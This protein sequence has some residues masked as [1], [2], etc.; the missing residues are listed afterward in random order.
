[1]RF[2][3]R[4]FHSSDDIEADKIINIL[5]PTSDIVTELAQLYSIARTYE[6][7]INHNIALG[8]KNISEILWYHPTAMDYWVYTT[9]MILESEHVH[10]I[11][12]T[13]CNGLY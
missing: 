10:G 5:D 9:N 12:T 13:V 4:E 7:L 11:N 3:R 2:R 8:S 1:M 6:C